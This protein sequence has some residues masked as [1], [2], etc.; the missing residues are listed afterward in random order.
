MNHFSI[1]ELCRS[2]TA[3]RLGIDNH[4]D[5]AAVGNLTELMD[6]ILEPLRD[7]FGL[8]I[9]VNSGY[10]CLRLNRA[11]GGADGSQHTKGQAAD[12]SAV[13][14]ADNARLYEIILNELPFDQLIWEKGNDRFPAWVHVSYTRHPRHSVLRIR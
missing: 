11:V 10:R 8:P 2:T 1:E 14:T 12:I 4:P 5:T 7:R 3:N 6:N 9:M 13:N